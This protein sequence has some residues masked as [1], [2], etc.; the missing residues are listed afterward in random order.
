VR[1]GGGLGRTLLADN[2]RQTVVFKLLERDGLAGEDPLQVIGD[3]AIP[4]LGS[5]LAELLGIAAEGDLESARRGGDRH[6]PNVSTRGCSLSSVPVWDC[7][8]LRFGAPGHVCYAPAC[9]QEARLFAQEFF[10]GLISILGYQAIGVSLFLPLEL[11]F[12]KARVRFADRA[13]GVLFLL[14]VAPLTALVGA[15]LVVI[16][17]ALGIRGVPIHFGFGAPVVASII[18]ALWGD[19]QFYVIHRI[20]HR[21]FWRF[22]AVHHAI[23][24]PSAANSYHHWTEPL[25]GLTTAIPLLFLDVEIGPTL[26]VLTFLFTF[27]QFY[28]HS[29]SRVHF[30]PLRW[31]LVDNRYHRIHHS[32][33]PRHYDLNFGAGTPLW[34]WLFGTMYMPA[35]SEWPD[36][37]LKNLDESRNLREWS[38]APFRLG[39]N[40]GDQAGDHSADRPAQKVEPGVRAGEAM[41]ERG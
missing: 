20:E 30:G 4:R 31:V 25:I 36:V 21:F 32:N 29:A 23:R 10:T 7:G 6:C 15:T 39:S 40:L 1:L 14:A 16:K 3:V 41:P 17:S 12:P 33:D 37:G 9:T 34:D 28:I 2:G 22:H 19:L 11:A 18:A 38:S 35:S 13:R 8:P 5:M 24:N 27:Q 26:G